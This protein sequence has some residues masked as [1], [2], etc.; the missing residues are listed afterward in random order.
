MQLEVIFPDP[1]TGDEVRLKYEPNLKA[2]YADY[3]QADA[4]GLEHR[5]VVKR[6]LAML[7]LQVVKVE[8]YDQLEDLPLRW[9]LPFA[10]SCHLR[11]VLG[12]NYGELLAQQ[13][14][15]ATTSES[16]AT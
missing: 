6:D 1:L 7:K 8:G 11:M 15:A 4:I 10:G 9:V 5:D 14:E 12:S 3:E 2:T 16:P 13:S